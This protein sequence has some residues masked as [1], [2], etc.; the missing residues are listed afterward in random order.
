[1]MLEK[2]RHA[3][4]VLSSARYD[5]AIVGCFQVAVLAAVGHSTLEMFQESSFYRA[6]VVMLCRGRK[7]TLV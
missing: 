4:L 1:M 3:Y 2:M 7:Y 5:P 6:I